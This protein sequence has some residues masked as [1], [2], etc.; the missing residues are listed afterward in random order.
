VAAFAAFTSTPSLFAQETRYAQTTA[1]LNSNSST[2]LAITGLSIILPAAVKGR[3]EALVTLN[4]PNLYLGG[5]PNGGT[6]GAQVYV[7]VD[8]VSVAQGQIS[9][10]N[11]TPTGDGR[12]PLTIV[13]KVPLR[14][15][16]QTVEAEWN[17]VRSST[18]LTDTFASLSAVLTSN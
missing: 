5:T 4:M 3:T 11:T 17:G 9:D 14:S 16:Q 6:R 8:G 15:T 7:H 10:D 12:K 1:A 18:I 2:P 13:V